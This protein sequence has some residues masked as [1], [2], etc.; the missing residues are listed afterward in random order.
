MPKRFPGRQGPTRI[1]AHLPLKPRG[2]FI[3]P[4]V[5]MDAASG[6]SAHLD[7]NRRSGPRLSNN[8]N[9]QDLRADGPG[10]ISFLGLP[11]SFGA[12]HGTPVCL[13]RFTA[14]S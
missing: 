8:H 1:L 10:W 9:L 4:A 12:T 2:I 14:E 6:T 3:V 5:A 13:S 11:T 7:T